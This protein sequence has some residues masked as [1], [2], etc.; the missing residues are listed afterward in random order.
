M[1]NAYDQYREV[2]AKLYYLF[3]VGAGMGCQ[4]VYV[5][6]QKVGR[7]MIRVRD[8]FGGEAWKYP[9][10][11]SGRVTEEKFKELTQG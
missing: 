11:F 7:K 1:A 4:P 6:V 2:G 8:E 5:T 10:F 9:W 3:D